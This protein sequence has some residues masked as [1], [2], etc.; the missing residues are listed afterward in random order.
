MSVSDDHWL[1]CLGERSFKALV[2][3]YAGEDLEIPRCVEALVAARHQLIKAD[4][5]SG[6][7]IS[8]IARKYHYT[9]RGIRKVL[10]RMEQE[11]ESNQ[12][13]IELDF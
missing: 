7:S 8:R 6:M 2:S 10:R 3:H 13:Q 1:M 5:D 9:E 4:A 12:Q 11:Q